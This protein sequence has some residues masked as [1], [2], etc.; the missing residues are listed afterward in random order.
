MGSIFL[1]HN[2]SMRS[3]TQ[4]ERARRWNKSRSSLLMGTDLVWGRSTDSIRYQ[5][6]WAAKT[7][8]RRWKRL[9]KE[10]RKYPRC[11]RSEKIGLCCLFR[12]FTL[13]WYQ[14][15]QK[16]TY[17]LLTKSVSVWCAVSTALLSNCAWCFAEDYFITSEQGNEYK[18]I[19]FKENEGETTVYDVYK[20]M[21]FSFRFLTFASLCPL[22]MKNSP[23]RSTMRN[24][25]RGSQTSTLPCKTLLVNKFCVSFCAW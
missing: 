22:P 24:Q 14:H 4:K 5:R 2:L 9:W 13:W 12:Y 15:V 3:S 19:R 18:G 16:E 17:H 8:I 6:N 21:L 20:C 10:L 11:L 1:L 7:L 25:L 23:L